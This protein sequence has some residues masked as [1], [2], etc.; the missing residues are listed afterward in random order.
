MNQCDGCKS[1]MER[2]GNLHYDKHGSPVMICQRST[3]QEGNVTLK[4]KQEKDRQLV[5]KDMELTKLRQKLS[6]LE[7]HATK[8]KEEN[9]EWRKMVDRLRQ[10]CHECTATGN[11]RNYMDQVNPVGSDNYKVLKD[12]LDKALKQA[13]EGKGKERH[14]TDNPFQD[15]PICVITQQVGQGYPLG[16][17]I[18]KLIESQRLPQDMARA[19]MLGAI[20]YI[21][22]AYHERRVDG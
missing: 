10:T 22:A 1:G 20:N 3:Y 4:E 11:K 15:Q 21:A 13:S 2:R 5:D 8:L 19:E 17:A 18:K 14:A 12:V 9:K 6:M 7:D 16:Q